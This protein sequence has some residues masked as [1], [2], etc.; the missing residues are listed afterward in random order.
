MINKFV[1]IGTRQY[2]D[3]FYK[4]GDAMA[5]NILK[6]ATSK[7]TEVGQKHFLLVEKKIRRRRRGDGE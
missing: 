2:S 7:N 4:A 5:D 3:F 1:F 6:N